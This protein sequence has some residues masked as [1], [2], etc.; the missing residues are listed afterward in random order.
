MKVFVIEEI[1]LQHSGLNY[2]IDLFFSKR[3]LATENDEKDYNDRYIDYEIKRQRTIEKEFDC[4]FIRVNLDENGFDV[5]VEIGKIYNHIKESNQKL[6]KESV[7]DKISKRLLE[8]KIK[9]SHSITFVVK[10]YYRHYK[11][12]WH[13]V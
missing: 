9:S 8:L 5:Y 4:E 2:K 13:I 11:T 1:L 10:K 12:C 7:I 3:R 6:T